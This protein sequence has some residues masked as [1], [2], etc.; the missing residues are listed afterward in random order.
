MSS[1]THP[2]RSPIEPNPDPKINLA[3]T[4]IRRVIIAAIAIVALTLLSMFTCML[5][6]DY[7]SRNEARS[8][9]TRRAAPFPA[10]GPELQVTPRADLQA[11]RAAEQSQLSGY[12]WVDRNTGVVRLPIERAMQLIAEEAREAP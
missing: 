11:V 7:L 1:P 10:Q 6:L 12:G 9:G 8:E 4:N 3:D 5:I 2:T